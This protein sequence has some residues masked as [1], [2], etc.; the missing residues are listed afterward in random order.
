[1]KKLMNWVLATTLICGA[2]VFTSCSESGDNP[3]PEN[4]KDRKEFIAH[5][6]DALKNVAENLNFATWKSV[7]FFAVNFNQHVLLNE[8]F[9]KTISKTFG[10]KIQESIKP[11]ELIEGMPELEADYKYVATVDLTDFN[12]TFTATQTGFEVA[13]N[14]DKGLEVVFPVNAKYSDAKVDDVSAISVNFKGTGD[15]FAIEDKRL[16][17]DSVMVV[18]ILPAQYD[19]AISTKSGD[20]WTQ[21]L[22]GTIKNTSKPSD[23]KTPGGSTPIL[24]LIAAWNMALDLHANIPDVD[25]FDLYFAIG[26]DPETHKAGLKVDYAH[27]GY[28]VLDATAT[29]TNANGLTDLTNL[30]TSS[31]IMDVLSAIMA[32][33]SIEKM[34]LTL[35]DDLTT[36]LKVSDCEKLVKLQNE[37][38]HARRNYADQ[39]TI[40]G[41]VEQ[42]NDLVDCSM[43]CKGVNQNIPMRLVT[44]KIGVD[45][46]AVPGLNFADEKGY[47]PMTEL[48]DKESV[49]YALNIIDHASEPMQFSIIMARQLIQALQ[50]LQTAFYDSKAAADTGAE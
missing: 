45:W 10:E 31:S 44:T 32:G 40:E 4:A 38:A 26:Q 5:T 12:Y 9:E 18:I 15:T 11:F 24:P 42:I 2:S 17:N 36:N 48:I 19:L 23:V 35:L 47:V 27:N 43:T 7:N 29:L 8:A 16:S 33:N 22:Y 34:E 28:K 49:E 6:R 13:E 30:T 39:A 46:W 50:K 41:Y 21:N 37:M 14:E 3:A 1:M 20:N 25:G